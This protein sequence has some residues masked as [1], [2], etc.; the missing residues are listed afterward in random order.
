MITGT[1]SPSD[2]LNAQ[3]LHRAKAV[4]WYYLASVVAIVIGA[5]VYCFVNRNTGLI[6]ACAGLGG[7]IGEFV[8][9]RVYLPWKVR[10][11]HAQQKDLASPFTYTW[12]SSVLEAQGIS[13]QS[14]PEWGN[15][16]KC[17]EDEKIFL[18]YHADN[19]FEMFPKTWFRDQDQMR[20]FRELANRAGKT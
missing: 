19:L 20:E 12:N 13:G 18:L 10:R 2:Y 14:K 15:Y 8:M 4:R 5:G 6:L 17:K 3:R 16:A 1:I 9:S 7:L 11:L